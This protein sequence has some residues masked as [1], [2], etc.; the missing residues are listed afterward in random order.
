[1]WCGEC[2]ISNPEFDFHIHELES[3]ASINGND[4]GPLL[5]NPWR[6][7][8]IDNNPLRSARDGDHL[9]APFECDD[10]VFLK[11]RKCRP[12][13]AYSRDRLLLACI[14]RANLDV[15]WSRETATINSQ[16]G[17][18]RR[19]LALSRSVGLQGP[20][21]NPGPL[22]DSGNYQR[23]SEDP[24]ASLWLM[25]FK[26]GC[27]RRMGQDWRPDEAM[28]PKLI[29]AL[30]DLLDRKVSR[31]VTLEEASHWISAR[32]YFLSLYV[33][34]LRGPEGLLMDLS[35][36]RESAR[37]GLRHDP[38]YVVMAL[39]GKVKGET[40]KRH[41]EMQSVSET[42]SGLKLRKAV[43]SL[44]WVRQQEGRTSGPAICDSAGVV[45]TTLV[46]NKILHEL[47]EILFSINS[48]LFPKHISSFGD[49]RKAYHVF[50]SFRRGSDS[51]AISQNVS[52]LDINSINRWAQKESAKGR[53]I[54]HKKLS[55]Y[56][57]QQ[58]LLLNCFLRYT[59]AM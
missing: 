41:H 37:E 11:L 38:P 34:S 36:I 33:F 17:A 47:L 46:A 45:W 56:Y 22:P 30:I 51:R 18:V 28:S 48:S 2:Y 5:E 3:K 32:L 44:L 27:R 35:G 24:S 15:F 6:E 57:A 49:I 53:K 14:R 1:M 13:L 50:R 29:K 55:Q 12:N 43:E 54:P 8:E 10:C 26:T 39:L 31:S 9:M 7:A 42:S 21:L 16:R 20:Y 52:E 19:G 4:G 40:H 23:L 25:R 58:D 59:F